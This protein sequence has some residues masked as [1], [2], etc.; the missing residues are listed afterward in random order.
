MN[1]RIN[2]MHRVG[3]QVRALSA[4][5]LLPF[6]A[7]ITMAET[8]EGQVIGIVDGDTFMLLTPD[9]Q[10]V[11]VRVAEI[12]AP[13][14][15]Q[16]YATRSRQQ[17]ADLIF[18]K[19]V[20]VQVQVVDRYNRPVGRPLVGDTDVTV[21]MIRSGAAWVYR[22]YSD[23][24]ELYELERAAKAKLRGLWSLPEYQRV[25]PWEYRNGERSETQR[26]DLAPAFQC[27]SKSYCGEMVSCDEARFY[28]KTCG[29]TRLDGDGDGLP[30]EAICR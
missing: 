17:L 19:E 9:K 16:P 12:D 14:R 7:S 22:S 28:L 29:L 6:V 20:T 10:Q 21:E 25:P 4:A 3:K 27:G 1:W 24:V 15:G 2:K 30:C 23:D 18:Q 26:I 11:N 5:L 13:E 8:V